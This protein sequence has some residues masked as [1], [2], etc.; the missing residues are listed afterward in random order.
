MKLPEKR[1][2]VLKELDKMYDNP[3]CELT[4]NKDYEL[5][6]KVM[7]SAQT[8]DK[9]V[10]YVTSSLFKDYDTLEKLNLLSLKEIE[11]KIKEIGMYKQKSRY[12]KDIVE[13]LI[14]IGGKVPNDRKIL[15]SMNGIGRKTV[16]VVVSNLFNEP[17]IAV[18]THVNRV[19]KRLGFA[20]ESDDV[21]VV[22]RKLMRV[23]PK[24]RWSRI[25]HQM[26]L[27]GRYRCKAKNPLC[28][29]CPFASICKERQKHFDI[30]SQ[31]IKL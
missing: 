20:K 28:S 2:I 7:L 22:E 19:S 30:D 5:L 12:F 16:N 10:N 26:V 4:Y 13:F 17:A 23:F 29:D 6:L 31:N 24:E 27:F 1:D 25:H 14:Q 8:T 21:L 11:N 3:K 18:D 15:E 9:R